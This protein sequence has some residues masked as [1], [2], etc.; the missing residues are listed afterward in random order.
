MRGISDISY[1][2][3]TMSEQ[4]ITLPKQCSVPLMHRVK[5][6]DWDMAIARIDKQISRAGAVFLTLSAM[7]FI[8]IFISMFGG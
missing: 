2:S 3:M 5:N 4:Q 1:L 6:T 7:Y 8:S